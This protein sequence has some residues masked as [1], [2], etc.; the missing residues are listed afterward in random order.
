M[1]SNPVFG[2]EMRKSLFRR[3]PVLCWGMWGGGVAIVVWIV[4]VLPSV[5]PGLFERFPHIMLPLVAPAFAAG[6]FAREREQ[7]T[8]QDLMLTPLTTRQLL[9][10]KFF[11]AY[12]PVLAV[13]FTFLPA[14]ILGYVNSI[15]SE[16]A[17]VFAPQTT[18]YTPYSVWRQPS[19]GVNYAGLV[20][21]MALRCIL[22][23][24]FYVSVALVC[25]HY[26][27]KV[28]VALAVCYVSLGIYAILL[29]LTF[30]S[31]EPSYGY[32]GLLGSVGRSDFVL[33]AIEQMHLWTCL[34]ITIGSWVLLSVGLRVQA[35]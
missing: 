19:G 31:L 6:A 5:N 29:L 8:W 23:A 10:G 15:S 13:L 20:G 3:K 34:V 4:N 24:A 18:Y 16:S 26:C 22:H 7:R 32:T 14:V 12:L 11:A 21:S 25:S 35:E 9:F 28:R 1:L 2:N 17:R 33:N 30:G 27:G